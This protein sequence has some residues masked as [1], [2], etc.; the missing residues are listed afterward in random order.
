MPSR[1]MRLAARRKRRTRAAC[2]LP[3]PLCQ[4]AVLQVGPERRRSLPCFS[5]T[6]IHCYGGGK[7]WPK[8]ILQWVVWIKHDLDRNALNDLSEIAGSIIRR[9]QCKLRTTGGSNLCHFAVKQYSRKSI[10][11]DIGA[12]SG[13]HIRKLGLAE[14]GK[15]PNIALHEL[16]DLHAGRDQLARQDLALTYNAGHRCGDSCISKIDFGDLN[17]GLL[18]LNIGS[19]KIVLNIERLTWAPLGKQN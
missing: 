8:T 19:I 6:C 12:V 10:D 11:A 14:V 18:R 9:K 3:L 5:G 16:Q 7:T 15:K 4:V 1:R 17:S 2:L 13:L